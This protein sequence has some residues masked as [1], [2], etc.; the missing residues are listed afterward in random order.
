VLHLILLVAIPMALI[1]VEIFVSG[2]AASRDPAKLAVWF[3]GCALIGALARLWYGARVKAIARLCD[4]VAIRS[5]R[6]QSIEVTHLTLEH[7]VPLGY[8]VD[9][10]FSDSDRLAFGFWTRRS[11]DA[12][13][14]L[15]EERLR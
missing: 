7:I 3:G 2:S 12:V 9:V 6:I 10:H 11:A 15:I 14:A 5:P 13:R 1:T 4:A 8:E